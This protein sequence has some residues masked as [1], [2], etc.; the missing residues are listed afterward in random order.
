MRHLV[1]EADWIMRNRETENSKSFA[2]AVKHCLAKVD[3]L[4]KAVGVHLATCNAGSGCIDHNA[5]A[6]ELEAAYKDL[7]DEVPKRA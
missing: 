6:A 1:E 5:V 3:R 4:R 7:L 2:R